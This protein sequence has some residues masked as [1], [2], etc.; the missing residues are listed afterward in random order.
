M[1]PKPHKILSG[2]RGQIDGLAF[3]NDGKL[4]ATASN[5][6]TVRIWDTST[7]ETIAT[8]DPAQDP[9]E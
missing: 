8:L 2:H 5:D 9:S 4:L 1:A 3:S 6:A 7:G